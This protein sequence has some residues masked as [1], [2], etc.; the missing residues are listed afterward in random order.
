MTNEQIPDPPEPMDRPLFEACLQP[1]R[2]L[3]ARGFTV[4]V[5]AMAAIGFVQGMAFILIGAWPVVGF[6]GVEWLLFWWLFRRHFKGDLRSERVIL[7][8]DRL[9]VETSDAQGRMARAE[10]QPYWLRVVLEDREPMSNTLLLSSH[11]KSMEI[12][13]FLAPE[14]RRQFAQRLRA[15]LRGCNEAP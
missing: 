12:A 14:E 3:S 10:W 4:V 5:W 2:S 7:R 13:R 11:G 15:A 6:A 8:R 1:H 9:I